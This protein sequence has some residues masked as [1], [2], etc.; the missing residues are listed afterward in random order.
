M[1]S[2]PP[3]A[4]NF[5]KHLI[6]ER[7][8]STDT[9][10]NGKF[11][12]VI[13]KP[14][15]KGSSAKIRLPSLRNDI[16]RSAED[17]EALH[18]AAKE[19]TS[20][21]RARKEREIKLKDFKVAIDVAET[22]GNDFVNTK[23]LFKLSARDNYRVDSI[24][25]TKLFWTDEKGKVVLWNEEMVK[26]TSIPAFEALGKPLQDLVHSNYRAEVLLCLESITRTEAPPTFK[27]CFQSQN[28]VKHTI[29]HAAPR[30]ANIHTVIGGLF[31]AEEV[32]SNH[33]DPLYMRSG[34]GEGFQRLLFGVNVKV[35][36][37]DAN[38]RFD[39][40][41]EKISSA[42]GYYPETILG[43]SIKETAFC[44]DM[45]GFEPIL[46]AALA[47]QETCKY[48]LTYCTS[49]DHSAKNVV[50][51]D[52]LSRKDSNGNVIGVLCVGLDHTADDE[53]SE[54]LESAKK[55]LSRAMEQLKKEKKI[56][57]EAGEKEARSAALLDMKRRFVRGVGHEIRTPLNVVYAGLQLLETKLEGIVDIDIL[58]IIL[59]LKQSCRDAVDILDDL[60]SYEKIDSNLLLIEKTPLDIRSF[61]KE[62]LRPF[63]V[64]ARLSQ[65]SIR[66][67]DTAIATSEG[68]SDRNPKEALGPMVDVD[69]HKVGQVHTALFLLIAFSIILFNLFITGSAKPHIKCC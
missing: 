6:S 42:S 9:E 35:F 53:K 41:N 62:S 7:F 15:E 56:A 69:K 65:V 50:E 67:F 43:A 21:G 63:A 48:E 18:L 17:G 44:V 23:S 4:K 45:E 61:V 2:L 59:D 27:I 28:K 30:R 54:A 38:M 11:D 19:R 60:L 13:L 57:A 46:Q 14:L 47:G 24:S 31:I 16:S 66:Y 49:E 39:V 3:L 64:Q 40:W 37:V 68:G 33:F 12:G 26:C 32:L 29:L 1:L 58:D 25:N 10:S 5:L 34:S 52:V 20:S 36:G 8:S 22:I 51:V 55:A